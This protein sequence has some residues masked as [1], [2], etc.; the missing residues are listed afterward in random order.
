MATHFST[1]TWRIPFT[2]DPGRLRS[3]GLQRVRHDLASQQQQRGMLEA[4]QCQADTLFQKQS[5]GC[6][7]KR[8]TTCWSVLVFWQHL[9]VILTTTTRGPTSEG[10][11]LSCPSQVTVL[12][13]PIYKS[14]SLMALSRSVRSLPAP[15]GLPLLAGT[16]G[17]LSP[18]PC[19]V[20]SRDG[21][22]YSSIAMSASLSVWQSPQSAGRPG[23]PPSGMPGRCVPASPLQRPHHF[24]SHSFLFGLYGGIKPF[25]F[26]GLSLKAS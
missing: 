23:Y 3:M 13:F 15:Q 12:S 11:E 22:T 20:C 8:G 24:P 9:T 4:H 5:E 1:L 25:G 10:E 19:P 26:Q 2:E 7:G 14:G 18:H 6:D 17:H 16:P 21:D